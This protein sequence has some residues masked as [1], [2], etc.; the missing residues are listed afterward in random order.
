MIDFQGCCCCGEDL[1]ARPAGGEHRDGQSAL[2]LGP[3]SDVPGSDTDPGMSI[4]LLMILII[5]TVI[6]RSGAPRVT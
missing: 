5:I 2:H 3:G 1:E 6:V 4:I